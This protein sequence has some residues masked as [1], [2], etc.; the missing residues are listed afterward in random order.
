MSR[1]RTIAV[2]LVALATTLA[3]APASA[4]APPP[5]GSKSANVTPLTTLPEANV[6][7]ANFKGNLMYLSTLRGLS[8]YDIAKPES[9]QR[10]STLPLPHFENEDVDTNG[11]ILLISNDPSEGLGVL[12]VIDVRDP[13]SPRPIGQLNT[14]TIV[15]LGPLYG[16]GHTA[17]CIQNCKYA[18]LAGTDQGIDIVDLTNPAA[19]KLVGNFPA[20]EVAGFATHD[21]QVRS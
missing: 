6:I 11:E 12:Y 20:E 1:V 8:I 3:A 19:P 18:Y 7:S 2:G 13:R 21:V 4:Q 9:P 15:P 10:L 17:S 14:G 16:T 5:P